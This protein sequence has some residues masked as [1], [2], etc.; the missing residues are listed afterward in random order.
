MTPSHILSAASTGD[1]DA[2]AVL[3]YNIYGAKLRAVALRMNITDD[4]RIDDY[5]SEFYRLL[6]TPTRSREWRLRNIC[7]QGNVEAYLARAFNNFLLD[8]LE[9]EKRLPQTTELDPNRAC[10]LSDDSDDKYAD[11]I[12]IEAL[13]DTLEEC[14]DF[15]PRTRYILL[16][17][18]I[19]QK[20]VHEGPPLKLSEKLAEQLGMTPTN[21]YNTYTRALAKLK[22]KAAEAFRQQ[23]DR[24]KY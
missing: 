12:R 18:L 22:E 1:K 5:V 20:Y 13:L 16:T 9:R 11:E 23:Y 3:L 7:D 14:S 8:T 15:A 6:I 4:D 17:Y 24:I 2:I 21:V 19:A 10:T